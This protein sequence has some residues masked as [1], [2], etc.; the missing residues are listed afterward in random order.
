MPSNL[1]E[2]VR[3]LVRQRARSLC[4]YCHT[5]E[6][7]QYVPFTIDHV[8]PIQLNGTDDPDNLALACFHCNRQK[9]KRVSAIDPKTGVEVSLFN[10]RQQ[11]WSDHFIWT[12]DKLL[13]IGLTPSGRA[14]VDALGLNR[15]RVLHLRAADLA[16][17]RHP[18]K[19]DP[20]Q[21]SK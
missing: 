17:E 7:W 13:I 21:K 4:E 5:D 10:P 1:P 15:E 8:Q 12:P 20:V 19:G 11:K 16:V 18:P 6:T 3:E 14:T 2:T 9:G